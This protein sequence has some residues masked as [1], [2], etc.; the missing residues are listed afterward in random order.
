MIRFSNPDL[1]FSK[2][3]T[4]KSDRYRGYIDVPT[5]YGIMFARVAVSP[6]QSDQSIANKLQDKINITEVKRS[7]AIT[8]A[9]P[10]RLSLFSS[11]GY[12]LAPGVSN[13]L[14]VL[15]LTA[16]IA[17]FNPPIVAEDREKVTKALFQSG[18]YEDPSLQKLPINTG[19]IEKRVDNRA[20]AAL[21]SDGG[22]FD[23]GN[24]WSTS[25]PDC[26]GLYYSNYVARY[27]VAKRGYLALTPDQAAYPSRSGPLVIG[28]NS[29]II[30]RF[31]RRPVLVKGGFWSLT[32]YTSDQ[33][34]IQNDLER[35]CLGDRD[36]MCFPDQTPLSDESKDGEFYILLQPADIMPPEVWR[37]NWLPAPAGGGKMSVTLRWY[38]ATKEMLTGAYKYPELER[39]DA[40]TSNCQY[41]L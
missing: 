14:V 4:S 34:L 15:R 35:Y 5:A 30:L 10:L 38:G 33:Y 27:Y 31:S 7:T 17:H 32:A 23:H 2:S 41:K 9:P 18:I 36:H 1:G 24:G 39:I 20:L 6:K 16:A 11:A 40:I 19:R 22:R 28:S 26:L 8:I 21:R 37:N 29:A 25:F 13:A 3:P 12:Q